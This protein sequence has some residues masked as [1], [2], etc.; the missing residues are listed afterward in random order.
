M[1][2]YN[3]SLRAAFSFIALC[4]LS[5]ASPLLASTAYFSV[6]L[7]MLGL[8]SYDSDIDGFGVVV[9]NFDLGAVSAE[10][11]GIHVTV[12][13]E[14]YGSNPD[15]RAW[16]TMSLLQPAVSGGPVTWTYT[17]DKPVFGRWLA[18][19]QTFNNGELTTFIGE[20]ELSPY[21]TTSW[22]PNLVLTANAIRNPTTTA[23]AQP[24]SYT[25]TTAATSY[26]YRQEDLNGIFSGQAISFEVAHAPEPT[27]G[28][29][30]MASALGLL[31]RR[32]RSC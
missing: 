6:N 12:T 10:L 1:V 30:L 2:C 21:T 19:A 13:A 9:S 11:A 3:S 8:T 22:N 5:L 27:R 18:P 28:V 20:G 29:L 26:G 14:P 7:S 15:S 32:R 25:A 4:F 17:F 24:F 23:V 31:I 16:A